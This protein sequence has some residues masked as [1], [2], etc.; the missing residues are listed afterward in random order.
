MLND[1]LDTVT[2][3]ILFEVQDKLKFMSNIYQINV[4][5]IVRIMHLTD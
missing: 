2:K 4:V 5:I 1:N 3:E